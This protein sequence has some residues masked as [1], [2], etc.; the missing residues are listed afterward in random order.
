MKIRS[1]FSTNKRVVGVKRNSSLFPTPIT[2]LKDDLD[3]FLKLFVIGGG[4]AAF[5][6][7]IYLHSI[8]FSAVFLPAIGSPQVLLAFFSGGAFF[9][10]YLTFVFLLPVFMIN[11]SH[12]ELAKIYGRLGITR[13]QQFFALLAF[14]IVMLLVLFI[15]EL[16]PILVLLFVI[17]LAI[18]SIGIKEDLCQIRIF[19]LWAAMAFY[20]WFGALALSLPMSEILKLAGGDGLTQWLSMIVYVVVV[21]LAAIYV[22]K[23]G[24]K[25]FSIIVLALIVMLLFRANDYMVSGAAKVL[26]M[27]HDDLRWYWVDSKIIPTFSEITVGKKDGDDKGCY[28]KA[29]TPFS[30]AD[31]HILCKDKEQPDRA[32][33][34]L[35]FDKSDAKLVTNFDAYLEQKSKEGINRNICIL[36]FGTTDDKTVAT[37]S[38]H[39]S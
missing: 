27:R 22:N 32:N 29:M 8:G 24:W 10:A 14:P 21:L 34:I 39:Q 16:W 31:I 36:P 28:L 15:Q 13:W 33:C 26:G 5:F 6:L 20:F 17:Q 1:H 25:L 3:V 11:P 37:D 18:V 4:A 35:A 7:L 9:A 30:A 23:V 2:V 19:A 12:Q 38:K